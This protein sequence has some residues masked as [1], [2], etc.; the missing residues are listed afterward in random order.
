MHI[1]MYTCIMLRL[2]AR[3]ASR[4]ATCAKE[5]A[6]QAWYACYVIGRASYDT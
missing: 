3:A 1:C 4:Y 6:R 2:G 5:L